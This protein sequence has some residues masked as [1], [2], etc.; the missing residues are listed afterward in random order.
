MKTFLKQ[1]TLC[2]DA[3]YTDRNVYFKFQEHP[4]MIPIFLDGT[5]ITAESLGGLNLIECGRFGGICG[6]KN[7]QCKQ[8]REI[9]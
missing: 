6:S 7:E 5:N 9:L 8:L 2:S 3:G 1:F 4:E